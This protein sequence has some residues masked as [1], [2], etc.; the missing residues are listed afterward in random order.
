[1]TI[2][3]S[4]LIVSLL[5]KVTGPSRAIGAAM[6][7]LKAAQDRNTV[8]LASAQARMLGAVGVAYSLG[9]A[10]AAP[11]GAAKDF[12]TTLSDIRQKSGLSAE[13]LKDLGGQIRAIAAATNQLPSATAKTFDALLGLGLGGKTDAENV[14]AALKLLPAINKT[15]TAFRAESEDVMRAGQAVFANLRVPAEQVQLAFDMM[16]ASGNAGAFELRDMAQYFPSI[17]AQAQALGIQGTKGV[18]DL[19]A[20]LQVVRQGAGDASEAA[21]NMRDLF[22][23][24]LS[25]R[26]AGNF[27]KFGF[28]LRKSLAAGAKKGESPIDTIIG[29]TRAALKKGASIG[30]LFRNQQSMLAMQ[31]LLDATERYHQIRDEA[32][33]A[34]GLVE[35]EYASRTRDADAAIIRFKASIE[36]LN[37]SLGQSLLPLLTKVIDN[38]IVPMVNKVGELA[39]EY[40]RLAAAVV[41]V[42][43]SLVGLR[44]AA[45]AAQF[46]LLWMKGGVISAGIAGLR[47]LQMATGAASVALVP[48]GRALGLVAPSARGAA[49]EVAA[50]TAA[51]LA[52]RQAAYQ[53]AVAMQG[54][55]MRGQ[56]VGVS[57][58]QATAGVREA[59]AALVAAQGNMKA[60]NAALAA[61]GSSVGIVTRAFNA[62]KAAAIGTGIGAVLIGI[63]MAGAWIYNNWTGISTAFEAFKG[64]FMRAI[65]PVMPA[66]QP[67][68]DIFST[69]WESVS[70]LLGPI[71]EMGGGW[72]RAGLAAGKF[73]GDLVVSLVELPGKVATYIGQMI[74]R[75]TAFGVEMI[76][77]GKELMNSLLQGI[78]SGAQAVLD[79]VAGIG[80]RIKSSITGA[81]SGVWDGAK[82][83]LGLGGGTDSPA[84]AGARAAGGPVRAG[85]TYLVGEHGP[86]LFTPPRSG[87]V[88]PNEVFMP[89]SVSA[90]RQRVASRS[91][92]HLSLSLNLGGIHGITD[93]EAI[94]EKVVAITTRKLGE[95]LSGIQSDV[96][97]SPGL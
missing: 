78:V 33:G 35:Q 53:A 10:L 49:K 65:E 81:V 72:A 93:P 38:G 59:G 90:P 62:L 96:E 73:V 92:Q 89:A 58:A 4:Q 74:D 67:V 6:S 54:L 3:T 39:K 64:A 14:D 7:R 29:L 34:S 27:K 83:R 82:S 26:L 41:A 61:T 2:L 9:R 36:N 17:T 45:I 30:D 5:D 50:Q 86:E 11:I 15:A 80:A 88:V 52:Q 69:L 97:Y 24:M 43:S 20:A 95:V 44:I 71:D 46:S 8:A 77:A 48:F 42:T 76:A 91:T 31:A 94:A 66:I 75:L 19:A 70:N 25:P 21:T 40:P 56:V 55:A 13:A 22:S 57:M 12:Q 85:S 79:Y 18:S 37:I 68:L 16:A 47:G 23:Q 63:A 28:N 1:M 51:T 60:A 84:V 32:A 87:V